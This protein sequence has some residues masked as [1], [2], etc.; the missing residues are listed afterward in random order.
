M[1]VKSQETK[2]RILEAVE[3][4]YLAMGRSPS[5]GE[6]ADEVGHSKSTVY[7]YLLEMHE[8]GLLTYDGKSIATEKT[9]KI[10]S[11]I[12]RAPLLGSIACGPL[13]SVEE[14]VEQYI[15]LP[16]SVFGMDDCFVLRA[17]GDSMIEAGINEGDL[18]VVQ[19]Q[20]EAKNGD[21]VVALVDNETT[22][23]RYFFDEE[24]N[25]VRLHPEN[26]SMQDIYP[27]QCAVQGIAHH[28]IRAL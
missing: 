7:R 21:I 15:A 22:L 10:D 9:E 3:S 24:E 8:E 17:N 11:Q 1:R 2:S 27:T 28:V 4:F 5:I 13:Q 19:K 26:S 23:K 12:L 20:I 6:L 16:A 14:M 25:R 18:V